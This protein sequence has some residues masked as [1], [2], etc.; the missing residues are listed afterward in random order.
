MTTVYVRLLDE[1]VD[2]FRPTSAE[3][4]PD[5]SYKLMP[6]EGYDPEL[7]HWEFV[8]DSVVRCQLMNLSGG[9]YL[10]AVALA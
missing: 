6:C 3:P 1:G 4:M 7:E 8:P 10:V 5:G 2:V 9:E